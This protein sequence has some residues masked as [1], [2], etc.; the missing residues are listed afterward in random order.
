M[1]EHRVLKVF[2]QLPLGLKLQDPFL[3]I[4]QMVEEYSIIASP[5][6]KAF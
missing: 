4:K 2:L 5:Q 3:G 6:D 1:Y